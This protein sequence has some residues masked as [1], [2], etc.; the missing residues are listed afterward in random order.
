MLV[1]QE[2]LAERLAAQ[3]RTLAYL[4]TL[5]LRKKGIM[6]HDVQVTEA[7]PQLLAATKV[8]TNLSRIG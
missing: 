1:H 3:E 4:E 5:I 6:P 2:R 8:H 7:V